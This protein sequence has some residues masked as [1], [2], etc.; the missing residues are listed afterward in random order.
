M[1][2]LEVLKKV[3]GEDFIEINDTDYKSEHGDAIIVQTEYMFEYVKDKVKEEIPFLDREILKKYLP[4]K[5]Q[6]D[7]ILSEYQ[8][9]S[10]FDHTM[11]SNLI[12][13]DIQFSLEVLSKIG[14]AE[15]ILSGSEEHIS[16]GYVIFYLKHELNS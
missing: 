8:E 14:A 16:D 10:K 11:L 15:I 1:N 2:K 5:F 4:E 13:D 7:L 6:N 9:L 3:I 12:E